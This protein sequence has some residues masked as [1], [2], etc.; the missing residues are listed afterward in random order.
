MLCNECRK[1]LAQV[2]DQPLGTW[3]GPKPELFDYPEIDDAW[4]GAHHTE[5]GTFVAASAAG[6]YV[7]YS[8]WRYCAGS[9]RQVLDTCRTF[10]ELHQEGAGNDR[11]AIEFTIEL[12][13]AN[14]ADAATTRIIECMGS[15]KLFPRSDLPDVGTRF[16]ITENTFAPECKTQIRQWLNLCDHEHEICQEKWQTLPKYTIRLLNIGLAD[17]G[18]IR[19]ESF[20]ADS[21][22]LRYV[23]LSHCWSHVQG[24]SRYQLTTSNSGYLEKG[25]CVSHLPRKFRDAID[26]ARWMN[27]QYLW[28]DA[29]CIMQDSKV[30]WLTQAS[31][32]GDIYS[33]SY[34]NIAATRGNEDEALLGSRPVK[35]V[36]PSVVPDPQSGSSDKSYILGYDDFWCNSL[37]DTR[38]H[39]RGWVLQERLLAPRT[40]HFGQEQFFFECR[41]LKACEAYPRGIPEQLSNWRTKAWRKGERV[42]SP[43][44]RSR[45]SASASWINWLGRWPRQNDDI[46]FEAYDCWTTMV[47]RYMDCGLSFA[48]DKL[49]AISGLASKIGAATGERYLVGLWDNPSLPQALLWYVPTKYQADGSPSRRTASLNK[50]G[51]RAPSWSW[52]SIDARITWNWPRGSNEHLATITGTDIRMS[53]DFGTGAIHSAKMH[54]QA[55]LLSV[56]LRVKPSDSMGTLREDMGYTIQL[57]HSPASTAASTADQSTI[58]RASPEMEA[59]VYLDT[60]MGVYEMDAWLL[61]LCLTWAGRSGGMTVPVAGLLLRKSHA[62][63]KEVFERIGIFGL[64]DIQV[65]LL[66]AFQGVASPQRLRQESIVLI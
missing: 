37:L 29:L 20:E 42:L 10:F 52:A 19:L 41:E 39:T 36:E 62:G 28:I 2:K 65:N 22:P 12:K 44:F 27:I 25:F 57:Q 4:R 14:A 49:I 23:T 53:G 43:K 64:D 6:C 1:V 50:A 30:D 34:C 18:V 46:H 60:A 5:D 59:I 3:I 35:I 55:P 8:I 9:S 13:E 33:G 17:Q 7:C 38:L 16:S 15:F 21:P 32:M 56:K 40:I 26:I 48:E 61:P 51:Y 54:V 11:Y 45:K 31:V 63:D 66:C 47:Q 24:R 58:T